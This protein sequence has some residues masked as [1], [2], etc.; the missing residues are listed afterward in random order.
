MQR[1]GRLQGKAALI[2]GGGGGIGAATA[3]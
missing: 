1:P 3:A 2:T